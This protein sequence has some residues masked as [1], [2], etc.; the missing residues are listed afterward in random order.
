MMFKTHLAIG[1]LVG[2]IAMHY[3][4]PS[5]QVLFMI[6]ILLGSLLP[7]IDHPNSTL[8][9]KTKIIA[10]LFEHRGFFHGFL[11]IIPLLFLLSF[12]LTKV[13]LIAVALGYASHLLSDALTVEGIMPLHP[14]SR[15]RLKGFLRTGAFYEGIFLL[16]V[17]VID[18]IMLWRL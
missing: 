12:I 4:Q 5:N 6:L 8:G 10:L 9:R 11:S 2:L 13:Q 14:L 16:G 18:V 17:V 15:W 7:D 3:I 1:F